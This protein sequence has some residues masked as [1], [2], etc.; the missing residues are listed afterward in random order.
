[1]RRYE[2]TDEQWELIA[3]LVPLQR[4][5]GRR[6]RDQKHDDQRHAVDPQ[7]RIPVA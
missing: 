5:P 4:G 6:Y 2:L 7:Q 3:D 1:M